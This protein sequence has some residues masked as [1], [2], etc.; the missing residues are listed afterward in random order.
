M[1][2]EIWFQALAGQV[3]GNLESNGSGK[4]TLLRGLIGA[5]AS[6]G[7]VMLEGEDLRRVPPE[8]L[9]V[10]PQAMAFLLIVRLGL[11]GRGASSTVWGW[12]VTRAGCFRNLRAASSSGRI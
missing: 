6:S 4:A 11:T 5:V 1:L 2:G 10:L 9:A 8:R 3:T 12:R 7:R